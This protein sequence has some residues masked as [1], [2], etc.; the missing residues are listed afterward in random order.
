MVPTLTREVGARLEALRG[1][2]DGF[3]FTSPK[4]GPLRPA[5]FRSRIWKP[6]VTSAELSKPLP[7]P[8]SLRHAAV[9]HWI[10]AGVEPYRLA[11]WA[12]HRSAA[13]IYSMYGH[14]I[15]DDRAKNAGLGRDPCG[16]D[17]HTSEGRGC[18]VAARWGP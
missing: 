4:G 8:H 14:M 15:S 11:T 16:R 9:A 6:A 1:E 10:A 2:P 18:A 17:R 3:V 7:T 5:A 12:G 13:T